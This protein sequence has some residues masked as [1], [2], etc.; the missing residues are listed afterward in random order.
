MRSDL[1]QKKKCVHVKMNKETHSALRAKLFEHGLSMQ[2]AL[3]EFACLVAQGDGSA[4]KIIEK[5]IAR[6]LKDAMRTAEERRKMKDTSFGELDSETLY[7][8]ISD[9][10]PLTDGCDDDEAA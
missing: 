2:E 4:T 8:M 5:L 3:D 10:E 1:L 6:K 7:S 9:G